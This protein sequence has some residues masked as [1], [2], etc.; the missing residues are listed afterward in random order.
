MA[1]IAGLDLQYIILIIVIVLVIS[2]IFFRRYFSALISDYVFDG[3]FSFLDNFIAGAGLIGLDLGDWIGAFFIF[4]RHKNIV[5]VIIA[6]FLA[7]EATNFFPISLIPVVG[8]VVEGFTGLFPAVFIATLLFN[9]F[10]PAE[11]QEK[12]LEEEISIAEQVGIDVGKQK[13]VIKDI[14]KLIKKSNPVGALKEFRSEKP[15]R[16]VSTKLRGYVDN[17]ISDTTNVIQY[18]YNQNIQAPQEMI[19]ILQQGINEA[20]QLL[21]QA[22]DAEKNE[23]FNNAINLSKSAKDTIYNAAYQFD[24]LFKQYQNQLQESDQ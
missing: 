7:W 24:D 21:R 17:L 15:V 13:K 4:I 5:G 1:S 2:F 8:E 16:N 9:K 18:I 23:D 12:K 3:L 20:E 11:K 22:Q 6:I 14:K 19:N 10:R